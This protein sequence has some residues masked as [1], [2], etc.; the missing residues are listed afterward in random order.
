MSAPLARTLVGADRCVGPNPQESCG[1]AYI[2]ASPPRICRGGPMC[3][4]YWPQQLYGRTR[5]SAPSPSTLR[6]G[7][8][9]PPIQ[10]M[11]WPILDPKHGTSPN[12]G[13]MCPPVSHNNCR[14]GPVCPPYAPG[15]NPHR[16]QQVFGWEWNSVLLF[17][18][19]ILMLSSVLKG[20]R[21]KGITKQSA[22]GVRAHGRSHHLSSLR[23]T[24]EEMAHAGIFYLVRRILLGVF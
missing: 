22:H 18:T 11:G 21:T 13:P 7:H 1:Q 6:G 23:S 10:V 12:G 9:G 8:T 3:P 2:R 4:P 20:S 16:L 24:N 5:V 14:G 17:S 19:R 15:T